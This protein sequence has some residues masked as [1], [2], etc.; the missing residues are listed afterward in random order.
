MAHRVMEYRCSN[1]N[2]LS[3]TN[4]E[5]YPPEAHQGQGYLSRTARFWEEM[6]LVYSDALSQCW[7]GNDP[8]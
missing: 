2:A 1:E 8:I 5:Y 7:I 4:S 6:W 3:S